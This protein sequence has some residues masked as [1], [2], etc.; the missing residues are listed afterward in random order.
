MMPGVG[1]L[2][3]DKTT[4]VLLIQFLCKNGMFVNKMPKI[5][6]CP[7]FFSCIEG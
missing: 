6:S 4:L 3:I 1:F 7:S 5:F 2:I